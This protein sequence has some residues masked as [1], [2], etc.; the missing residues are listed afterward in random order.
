MQALLS[1]QSL[2]GNLNGNLEWE[3]GEKSLNPIETKEENRETNKKIL[4]L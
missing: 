4:V 3:S 2:K 1:I